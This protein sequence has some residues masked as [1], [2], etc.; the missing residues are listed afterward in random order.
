MELT[1]CLIERRHMI[2]QR[3]LLILLFRI[4]L[5]E[6]REQEGWNV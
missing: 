6:E 5:I 2:N 1:V 4:V 3:R